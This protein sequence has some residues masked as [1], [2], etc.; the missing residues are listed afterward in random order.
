MSVI[1]VQNL[2]V[3]YTTDDAV[4]KA[5]Q[6][7]SFEIE[8]ESIVGLLGESGCGKSTL[9]SSLID[10]LPSNAR[11]PSGEVLING[12]D[13]LSISEDRRQEILWKDIAY[14]PQNAMNCL[15]PVVKLREQLV[16]PVII[17]T[18]K[19]REEANKR[20]EEVFKIVGIDLSYL[21]TYPHQLS[22]GMKQ[23]A[24]VAMSL[25]L[26]PEL[27][28]ADEPTTG[29]D[30]L[31]RDKI[32][33]DLER[34][35]DEFG[36]SIVFISHDIADLVETSDRLMV[37]YGGKIVE[38][39]PSRPLFE[40][41]THPYTIGLRNALPDINS[42]VEDLIDMEMDPP[43]L[44]SPPDGCCFV[45]RCPYAVEECHTQ[46]PPTKT[47]TDGIES[48]CYRSEEAELLQENAQKV[49]W[50]DVDKDTTTA[51]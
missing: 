31:V 25:V 2:S 13:I 3:E 45:N 28:I 20:A 34:F 11:T 6:D 24:V 46:H 47:D 50:V 19:S 18:S 7:V 8:S 16:E 4:I 17:H 39:G 32:L 5:V 23:R 26:N 49:S 1:T 10:F 14:I 15:D 9:A 30:V 38:R 44:R 40:S 51:D 22:G 42:S 21:D 36:V 48:A 27:I 37:M 43:N 12:E 35:R 41:P 29:L 33:H